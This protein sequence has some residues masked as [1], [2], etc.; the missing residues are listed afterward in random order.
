MNGQRGSNLDR[1]NEPIINSLMERIEN[2]EAARAAFKNTWKD[3]MLEQL[4]REPQG[5]HRERMV[6][7]FKAFDELYD[8]HFGNG[9][10]L[11]ES[12]G[13]TPEEKWKDHLHKETNAVAVYVIEGMGY[14]QFGDRVRVQL[15]RRE[16]HE[17]DVRTA[18]G[19]ALLEGVV[20]LNQKVVTDHMAKTQHIDV[21]QAYA[22][23]QV[24]P[25]LKRGDR[26]A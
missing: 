3:R 10:N 13:T 20:Q 16:I 22:Y 15:T 25:V 8:A 6:E 19:R 1:K 5:E 2:D 7:D 23:T 17:L 14:D 12:V 18:N 21:A 24:V 9:S 11:T 4:N 26:D